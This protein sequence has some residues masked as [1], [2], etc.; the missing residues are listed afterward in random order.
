[1]R[2]D[3]LQIAGPSNRPVSSLAAAAMCALLL[4]DLNGC[5]R[6]SSPAS[7]SNN[8][9]DRMATSATDQPASEAA[10]APE[11]TPVSSPQVAAEAIDSGTL[12]QRLFARHCAACH[13]E[14]GDGQGVAAPYLFPKPRNLRAGRF[15]LVSTDNNVPT[16]E[17]LQAVLLRGM[18]GSAMPPWGHLS[19]EDRD[20][21]VGEV[22]R[23]RREGA[24]EHYV[25]MLKDEEEMTDEEIAA[26]DV[27]QEIQDY[28]NEFTTPGEST[29]V[30]SIGSP[31]PEAIAGGREV[32]ATNGCIQ[33]HGDTGRGDGAQAMV[34]DEGMP[35]RPRD[36][37]LGIFKGNHDPASLYRRVAYGM[38]GTPM[39]SSS[40]VTPEQMADLVQYIRSLSTEEQR[41][42]ATL[43]RERIVARA[44][45]EVPRSEQADEWSQVEAVHLRMTPLW[46]R[47]DADPDLTVQAV[48]DGRTLAVRLTWK[49]ETD[50]RH[51]VRTESFRDAAAME[52]Y[53][54]AS[55]PFLGMGDAATP[56][57]V[58]FWDADRQGAPEAV[59]ELYPH[60][61][62]DNYPFSEAVVASAEL[63]RDG[64]RTGDQPDI[65][66]PARASGNLIVP[67]SD[68]SGGSSLH[69][70]GPGSVT[71]R[72]PQS[73]LVWAHGTWTGGRWTVLMKRPLSVP[74]EVDG[75]SLQPGGR[76][77]VAFAVWDG[78]HN[79][80]DGQ[81]SITIWQ[82]LELE[83]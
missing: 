47:N 42:A 67:N 7:P 80:R 53:R 15:R 55:E 83:K 62:V 46:W 40:N 50:N 39:P 17:D 6:S 37:T 28:V 13:G 22:M 77:S 48:H 33:C 19:D 73:Q 76:A 72:I 75:V 27:Q 25:Q 35:T 70:G 65:S 74:T 51:A 34:D 63:D 30:P 49:D 57:D 4:L 41:Q 78:A 61:V 32:Y 43:K 36:F 69:V 38:P 1:M 23:I 5:G 18:P 60:M 20:A 3:R 71:F 10:T 29:E 79:D 11:A 8:G 44:V 9:S 52:L 58:W 14:R 68:P 26:E 54:G 31:T 24:H 56:V 59:E 82:D 66:L 45:D 12:G 2:T 64:A 16:R 81:K 21:L